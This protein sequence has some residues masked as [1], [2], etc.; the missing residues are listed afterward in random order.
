MEENNASLL[1][2][3]AAKKNYHF[4]R[5]FPFPIFRDENAA[6]P[7]DQEWKY[8]IGHLQEDCVV[9]Y[10]DEDIKLL[11]TK[12]FFGVG[13]LSKKVPRVCYSTRKSP[14]FRNQRK[15]QQQ[16]STSSFVNETSKNQTEDEEIEVVNCED[17][18]DEKSA[19]RKE[20]DEI[21]VVLSDSDDSM[22]E[23]EVAEIG[24]NDSDSKSEEKEHLILTFEEAYFLS[25]GLGCL[26]V[27]DRGQSMDLLR[28]WNKFCELSVGQNFPIMY[29]AYHHFRSKGW[30]VRSGL[31][32]GTDYGKIS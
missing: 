31:K 10:D 2:T 12:G 16:S 4:T 6:G 9:V 8:V 13:S 17:D 14:D 1:L 29:T 27:K 19:D 22:S 30:V 20:G 3:P 25:Y 32:Y 18:E 11:F 15:Q 21:E 28:L 24:E 7:S 23:D 26:V 5:E